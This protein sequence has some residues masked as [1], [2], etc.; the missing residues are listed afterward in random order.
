MWKK[1]QEAS[2][3]CLRLYEQKRKFASEKLKHQ[4]FDS[5][6]YKRPNLLALN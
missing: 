3:G 5:V 1:D 6:K 4:Q 2:F